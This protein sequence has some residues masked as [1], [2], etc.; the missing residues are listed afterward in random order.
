MEQRRH[1]P[2]KAVNVVIC[3]ACMVKWP[4]LAMQQIVVAA[5]RAL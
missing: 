4:C 5:P 2:V 1:R 3:Q